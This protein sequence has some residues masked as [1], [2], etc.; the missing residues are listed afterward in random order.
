MTW[1][2]L[3]GF[4]KSL[5]DKFA[6]YI[7]ATGAALLALLIAFGKGRSAGKRVYR[8]KHERLNQRAAEKTSKIVQKIEDHGNDEIQRRLRRYYRD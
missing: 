6:F 7:M 1:V 5:W 8:E 2:L 3:V 4:L